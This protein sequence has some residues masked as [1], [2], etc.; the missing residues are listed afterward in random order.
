MRRC[1]A[2]AQS[3][4]ALVYPQSER[5]PDLMAAH[6]NMN[7]NQSV[8]VAQ[9]LQAIDDLRAKLANGEYGL[10]EAM[11]RFTSVAYLVPVEPL[12]RSHEE[13][14]TRLINRVELIRFTVPLDSQR[15]KFETVLDD[16]KSYFLSV[17]RSHV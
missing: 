7:D 13:D 1:A 3:R 10:S 14:V 4:W 15:Q 8:A 12:T 6:F 9:S 17:S 2:E 11:E 5:R 16:A